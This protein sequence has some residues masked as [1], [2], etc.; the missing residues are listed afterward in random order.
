MEADILIKQE[1]LTKIAIIQEENR[2]LR[3]FALEGEKWKDQANE[4]SGE[5]D[6][7]RQLTEDLTLETRRQRQIV[8]EQEEKVMLLML[9]NCDLKVN[10]V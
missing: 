4:M 2:L 3:A 10:F 7:L 8:N 6:R 9:L 5:N 1:A